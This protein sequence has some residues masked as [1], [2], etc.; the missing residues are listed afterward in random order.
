M[1]QYNILYTFILDNI[2]DSS[3]FFMTSFKRTTLLLDS[4]N[5][6]NSLLVITR[7]SYELHVS[8]HAVHLFI[9]YL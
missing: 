5:F 4:L 8:I 9:F 7:L 6:K 2:N 3:R 1:V